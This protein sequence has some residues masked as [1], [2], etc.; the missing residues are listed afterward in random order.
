M[1]IQAKDRSTTQRRGRSTKPFFA[2]LR[3]DYVK[4][5]THSTRLPGRPYRRCISGHVVQ[6]KRVTDGLLHC[7]GAFANVR[8]IRPHM[9]PQQ[10]ARGI[11]CRLQLR[12]ALALGPIT[13]P[14]AY[15]SGPESKVRLSIVDVCAAVCPE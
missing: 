1:G 2:S 4:F 11:R 5:N 14:G 7:F 10:L 8:P 9:Q 15:F 3:F 13:Q 12:V 6:F